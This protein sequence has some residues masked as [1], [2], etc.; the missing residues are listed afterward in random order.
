[1]MEL[2]AKMLN[3][4]FAKRFIIEVSQDPTHTY[5]DGRYLRSNCW[6]GAPENSSSGK[7]VKFSMGTFFKE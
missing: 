1:M 2:F 5:D 7:F 6:Q 4:F 3:S